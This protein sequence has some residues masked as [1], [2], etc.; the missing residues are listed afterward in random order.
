MGGTIVLMNKT[1]SFQGLLQEELSKKEIYTVDPERAS[2]K[3]ATM[4]NR[5]KRDD[6]IL[7]CS[8]K[9]YSTSR[10][11]DTSLSPPNTTTDKKRGWG[12]G[13]TSCL[14]RVVR[15]SGGE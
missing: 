3:N 4:Q 11:K 2:Y 7:Y 12:G 13:E 1:F 8:I 10:Y 14:V 6:D 15:E 5:Q 9:Y